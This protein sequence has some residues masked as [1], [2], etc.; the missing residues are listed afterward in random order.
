MSKSVILVV[1]DTPENIDVIS[2]V[3][4]PEYKVKAAISGEAALK[5]AARKPQPDLVL[6][7]IM[8]PGM[9]G[10]EVC[11]YL[12][13]DPKTAHIKVLFVSAKTEI[14][15]AQRALN[16]GAEDYITKPINPQEVRLIVRKQLLNKSA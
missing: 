16:L 13:A 12:K 6:L 10:F 8:M 1:D 2:G 9:D 4:K 15:D 14:S 3:L 11:Q 5:I 7:D